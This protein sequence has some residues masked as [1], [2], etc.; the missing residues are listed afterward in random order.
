MDTISLAVNLGPDMSGLAGQIGYALYGPGPATLAQARTTEGI[1]ELG[2]GSGCYG[3]NATLPEGWAGGFVLWDTGGGEPV[4]V[5][6]SVGLSPASER[7][8][9]ADAYLVRDW[10]AT[11]AAA[12]IPDRCAL[13]ALRTARNRWYIGSDNLMHVME[14][15]DVTEAWNA[16]ISANANAVPIT[17]VDPA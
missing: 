16:T 6:D 9:I 8:A 13:N 4:F 3:V 1:A 15:D 14:E 10:L 2:S 12:T 5:S 7:A 17:G 11:K